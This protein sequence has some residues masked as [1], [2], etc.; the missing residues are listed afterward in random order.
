M[1][2]VDVAKKIIA[3][4]PDTK[5][6]DHVQ[7]GIDRALKN[8]PSGITWRDIQKLA[9]MAITTKKPHK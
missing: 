3:F 4:N 2:P 7:V 6:F 8:S 1:K 9:K 5:V